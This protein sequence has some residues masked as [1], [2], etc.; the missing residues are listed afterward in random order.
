M[1]ILP[2]VLVKYLAECA[3][4]LQSS[5]LQLLLCCNIPLLSKKPDLEILWGETLVLYCYKWKERWRNTSS[6]ACQLPPS[7]T[8]LDGWWNNAVSV[9]R[10]RRPRCGHVVRMCRYAALQS[11]APLKTEVWRGVSFP[12]NKEDCEGVNTHDMVS[13]PVVR[14]LCEKG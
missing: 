8:R 12:L 10:V 13:W 9:F 4:L 14:A 7:F 5:K 3:T 6:F 2:A 11:A 1:S